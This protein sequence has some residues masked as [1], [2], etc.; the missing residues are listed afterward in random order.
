MYRAW[1][2][3]DHPTTN[4]ADQLERRLWIQDAKSEE[5]LSE[6]EKALFQSVRLFW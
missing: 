3:L 4:H 5:F 2:S 1:Y 6:W